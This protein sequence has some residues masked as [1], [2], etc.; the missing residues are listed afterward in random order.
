MVMRKICV[1]TGTRAEYGQLRPLMEMICAAADTKLQLV[2][3]GM[4]LS[5]EFGLTYREI[6]EHGFTIDRKIETLLSSDTAVGIGKSTGLGVIGF[7]GA[8]AD[9]EP[10]LV[11]LLG[12]RF[13]VLAAAVAALYARIPIAHIHGGETTEGA[14]DEGIRHAISKMSHLHFVAAEDYRR[15]VIQLGEDPARVFC[16]GGLG[17]DA[18]GRVELL[19][20]NELERQMG[21]RFGKHSLLITFHPVTL[22]ANTGEQQIEALLEACRKLD[23]EVHF[24]FTMPNADTGGRVIIEKINRFVAEMGERAYAA[25]SLGQLR[26]W[27]AL[28][29]VD[30][31]VGNSSSGIVEAPTFG[32]ATVNIGDRQKGRLMATSIVNCEPESDA[33]EAAVREVLSDDFRALARETEN[34]YGSGG[35]AEKIFDVI[36]TTS[37]D[38]KLLK[39]QFHDL[40]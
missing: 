23:P 37:L 11:V 2:V 12:D 16:V 17:V 36:T 31:V 1:V 27:S 3:T 13:E 30:A 38:G 18:I 33:I 25:T 7:A 28:Q 35:A 22:E 9:L 4:H 6:E 21:F 20:R 39:K 19:S 15:R 40:G 14:F 32:L 8:L 24:I 10:D 29:H 34:P 5:P 26:Y